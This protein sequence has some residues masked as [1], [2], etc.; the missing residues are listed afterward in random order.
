MAGIQLTPCMVD[1]TAN[2]TSTMSV[3]TGNSL[4]RQGHGNVT[5]VV[6]IRPEIGTGL[7]S[8]SPDISRDGTRN[9]GKRCLR[10]FRR[11]DHE[12]A[13]TVSPAPKGNA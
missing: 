2:Y 3:A 7:P 8:V 9:H 10:Q 12:I 11:V 1:G 4:G 6:R 13:M 5:H